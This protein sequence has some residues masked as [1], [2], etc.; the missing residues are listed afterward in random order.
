MPKLLALFVH[1]KTIIRG[2]CT[3]PITTNAIRGTHF[4][5]PKRI[6]IAVD[7]GGAMKKFAELG[8][9]PV[10]LNLKQLLFRHIANITTTYKLILR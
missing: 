10:K 7:I 6:V 2:A 3:K 8:M 4:V 5:L 9:G 1:L